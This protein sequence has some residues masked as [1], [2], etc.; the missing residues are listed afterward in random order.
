MSLDQDPQRTYQSRSISPN[1]I[2]SIPS[3]NLTRSQHSKSDTTRTYLSSPQ[4]TSL[5]Q[6]LYNPYTSQTT[7][8]D[9]TTPG[10]TQPIPI[11]THL[12]RSQH[13]RSHTTRTYLNPPQQSP[14]QLV[15]VS[16]HLSRSRHSRS[17]TT[18]TCLNPPQ[19]ISPFQVLYNSYLSQ[20]TSA[21][22]IS[23][24]P[25]PFLHLVCSL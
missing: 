21:D 9:L 7:S 20:P 14:I 2:K 24:C 22:L 13:S 11:S 25:T 10:P 1:P 5:L 4:V 19:P 23:F 18:R 3:I 6:V 16:T 15:P 17:H 12:K 8:G